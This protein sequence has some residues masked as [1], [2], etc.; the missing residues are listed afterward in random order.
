MKKCVKLPKKIS[1]QIGTNQKSSNSEFQ[2]ISKISDKIDGIVTDLPYGTASKTSEKPQDILK[3][4]FSSLP[5]KK[6]SGNNVQKRIR[7]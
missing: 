3:K 5:K 4:F 6:E 1:K 7:F 2:G